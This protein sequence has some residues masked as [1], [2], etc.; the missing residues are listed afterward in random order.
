[1][2]D[3]GN[4]RNMN[5]YKRS[6]L[7]TKLVLEW[8]VDK[9]EEIGEKEFIQI[10]KMAVGIPKNISKA[11][12]DINIK[13]KFKKLNQAKDSFLKLTDKLQELGMNGSEIGLDGLSLELLKLFNG[14][15]GYLAKKKKM[16]SR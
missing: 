13:E 3:I 11:V 2:E 10:R 4:P 9:R 7:Y 16:N 5:L 6:L 12:V 8:T 14:Y 15:F 1:M